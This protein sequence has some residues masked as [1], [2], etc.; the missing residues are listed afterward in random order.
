M[1]QIAAA[2]I[3]R[4]TSVAAVILLA[5]WAIGGE[6]LFRCLSQHVGFRDLPPGHVELLAKSGRLV[7]LLDGWNELDET[8]RRRT[9]LQINELKREYPE[10]QFV[11]SSRHQEHDFP[12]FGLTIKLG[13]LNHSQQSEIATALRGTEGLPLLEHAW[14]TSGLRELIEIPLYLSVLMEHTPGA[15]LPTTKEELLKAF[16][17]KHEGNPDHAPILRSE[18][19]ELHPQF[20]TAL[21]RAATEGRSTA[22][23]A[24]TARATIVDEQTALIADRQLSAAIPAP[25]VLDILARS[26]LVTRHPGDAVGFH[27]HQFLEWYAS[28]WVEKLLLGSF[29]GNIDDHKALR[30]RVLDV[31]DWEE[32][33]LFACE[34]L[35]RNDQHGAESVAASIVHTFWID[36]V[37]AAEMIFRSS[38]ETWAVLGAEAQAFARRWMRQAPRGRATDFMVSTGKAEFAEDLWPLVANPDDDRSCFEVLRAGPRFRPTVLGPDPGSRIRAL[39]EEHRARIISEIAFNGGVDGLELAARLARADDSVKVKTEA[40]DALAFRRSSST[41]ANLLADAPQAVWDH[42]ASKWSPDEFDDPAVADR[43]RADGARLAEGDVRPEF[44]LDQLMR[45]PASPDKEETVEQLVGE[46]DFSTREDSGRSSIHEASEKFPAA[47]ARGL[48]RHV[49]AATPIP[50][51]SE[52]LL[53]DSGIVLDEGPIVERLL[54]EPA[55]EAAAKGIAV[56]GP[57]SV[58]SLI[59]RLEI[60]HRKLAAHA[61]AR[62]LGA[63]PD[64]AVTDEHFRL[65]GLISQ[66]R[67]ESLTEAILARASTTDPVVIETLSDLISRH[68]RDA[69][70]RPLRVS[71]ADR[72]RLQAALIT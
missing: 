17:R 33:I 58:G 5:E 48:L 52:D 69:D 60:A 21:A 9:R 24:E 61:E 18:L 65:F 49:A 10:L 72:D 37:F 34:R 42:L 51:G 46:I 63:P 31:P 62:K 68:G 45:S 44:R 23:S 28:H 32:A 25:R 70:Q 35:S 27:H 26:H 7:L 59:D 41:L 20:L 54:A 38:E 67:F 30:E 6:T 11:V 57:V 1:L 39:P 14:R 56:A 13:S 55:S 2:I 53:R 40:A 22:L 8:A 16:V 71:E 15:R 29:A 64:R 43:I 12:V 4:R 19:H 3:E 36:P 47:V 66:S 50:Y